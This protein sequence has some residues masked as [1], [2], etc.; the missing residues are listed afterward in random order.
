M[1]NADRPRTQTKC[2]RESPPLMEILT[3]FGARAHAALQ[4]NGTLD[5][6]PSVKSPTNL[7]AQQSA[8]ARNAPH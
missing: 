8:K 4:F 5:S 2:F 7:S 6:D 1:E 3:L